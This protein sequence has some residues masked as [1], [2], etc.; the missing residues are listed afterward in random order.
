MSLGALRQS[1]LETRRA[2]VLSIG[3]PPTSAGQAKK[4]DSTM[5]C[6]PVLLRNSRPWS[7]SSAW[8]SARAYMSMP[9][10]ACTTMPM[11]A[12]R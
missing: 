5:P 4:S 10:D 12:V 11:T 3:R 7:R 1:N 9:K 2:S 8:V 6:R